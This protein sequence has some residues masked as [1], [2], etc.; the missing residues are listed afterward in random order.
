MINYFGDFKIEDVKKAMCPTIVL[1]GWWWK[2]YFPHYQ[3]LSKVMNDLQMDWWL[4]KGGYEE[5]LEQMEKHFE[6]E[7]LNRLKFGCNTN[8]INK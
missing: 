1:K 4:N 8:Y 6:K 3:K 5:Y 2:K 7:M